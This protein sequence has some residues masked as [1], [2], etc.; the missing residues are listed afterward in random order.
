M[1]LYCRCLTLVAVSYVVS[2]VHTDQAAAQPPEPKVRQECAGA[3]NAAAFAP[4]GKTFALCIAGG[5]AGNAVL[6]YDAD[7]GKEIRRLPGVAYKAPRHVE[8]A[9]DGK[10]L[11]VGYGSG[12]PIQLWDLNK[13]GKQWLCTDSIFDEGRPFAF[14][15]HGRVLAAPVSQLGG[16]EPGGD[17][18]LWEVASGQKLHSFGARPQGVVAAFAWEANGATLLAEHR[19]LLREPNLSKFDTQEIAVHRWSSAG[20]HLGS[21]GYPEKVR[22][23]ARTVRPRAAISKSSAPT[24]PASACSRWILART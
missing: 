15:P 12:G 23:L 13:E 9:P 6:L 21:V 2:A 20:K 22:H 5:A 24:P 18:V 10:T 19:V 11:A 8:F 16:P 7:T 17:L 1:G 14:A 3:V 4:D